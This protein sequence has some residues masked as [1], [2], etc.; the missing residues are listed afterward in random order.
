MEVEHRLYTF[1][2]SSVRFP[3]LSKLLYVW[4]AFV[5]CPSSTLPSFC[6][7][8]EAEN[9]VALGV[10]PGMKCKP[11]VLVWLKKTGRLGAT[12]VCYRKED[13]GDKDEGGVDRSGCPVKGEHV[14]F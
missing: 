11:P 6:E 9:R 1:K 2:N 3:C 10:F 14:I 4:Y 12:K 5:I 7:G 13:F 8:P